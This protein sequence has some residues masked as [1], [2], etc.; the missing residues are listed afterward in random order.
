[1]RLAEGPGVETPGY[2][3]APLRGEERTRQTHQTRQTSQGEGHENTP[4]AH[5]PAPDDPDNAER[6]RAA[7]VGEAGS[8]ASFGGTRQSRSHHGAADEGLSLLC[9]FG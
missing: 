5:F 4:F 8:P 7:E 3:Q 1:M 2:N 9:R 6:L